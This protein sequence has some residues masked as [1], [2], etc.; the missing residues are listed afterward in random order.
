MKNIKMQILYNK[1]KDLT[2]NVI[3]NIPA[4]SVQQVSLM[5]PFFN[6]DNDER[7]PKLHQVFVPHPITL[8]ARIFL[9]IS[10]YEQ[11]TVLIDEINHN[12]IFYRKIRT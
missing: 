10:E 2:K 1:L 5:I 7:N 9:F 6:A 4:S 12:E 11:F 3:K 8:N